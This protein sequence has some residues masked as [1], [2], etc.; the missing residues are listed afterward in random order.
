MTA[1]G[2]ASGSTGAALA[3]GEGGLTALD[4]LGRL[5]AEAGEEGLGGPIA[6]WLNSRLI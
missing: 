3:E 1:L 5:V 6:L 2:L 4:I